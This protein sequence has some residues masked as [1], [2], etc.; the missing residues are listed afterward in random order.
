M[1]NNTE[2]E[3]RM[4]GSYEE[5]EIHNAKVYLQSKRTAILSMQYN[6]R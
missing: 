1:S 3:K 4:E 5:H 6:V 2:A